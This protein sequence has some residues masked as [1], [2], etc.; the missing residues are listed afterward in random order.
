MPEEPGTTAIRIPVVEDDNS[1]LIHKI[2]ADSKG[3]TKTD[4]WEASLTFVNYNFDQ[5]YNTNKSF[6][7][8]WEFTPVDCSSGDPL[9][10]AQP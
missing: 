5:E 1:N 7:A 2:K 6:V 9:K 10:A 3:E 8:T 4:T